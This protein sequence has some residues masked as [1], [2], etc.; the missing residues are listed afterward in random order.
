MRQCSNAKRSAT[1]RFLLLA[2]VRSGVP[3]SF[4]EVV[5]DQSRRCALL[6]EMQR[7]R[8][9]IYLE[10]GAIESSGL[11]TDGRHRHRTDE[12]SW[13]LLVLDHFQRILGCMRYLHFNSAI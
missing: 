9:K 5:V 3:S 10:D 8:G 2:P 13:H 11:S 7:F 12:E 6:H 4:R 1:R